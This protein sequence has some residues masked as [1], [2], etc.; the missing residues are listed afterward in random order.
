MNEFWCSEKQKAKWIWVACEVL[1][2]FSDLLV[3]LFSF[4]SVHISGF[5]HWYGQISVLPASCV[6]VRSEVKV[7]HAGGVSS[8]VSDGWSGTFEFVVEI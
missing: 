6:P 3:V 5:V 8:G 1:S 4:R 2:G 7:H